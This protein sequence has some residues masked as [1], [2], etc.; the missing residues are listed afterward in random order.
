MG[1]DWKT[2]GAVAAGFDSYDDLPER[3][4]GYPTVF[5][6][7]KLGEPDVRTVL[8]YGCG[9]GKISLRVVRRHDVDVHAVD[10]S[11]SMLEIART[12]RPHPRITHHLIDRP[13]LD[14]LPD[15]SVDAAMC[16]Y[17]F[18]NIGDLDRIRAI[19][20][21]VHRVLR[22][23]GRFAV[24]DTNPDTTGIRFSTFESGAPGIRYQAGQQRRVQLHLPGGGVLELRDHH[25]PRDTYREVLADC[26]FRGITSVTPLLG[27]VDD[28]ED[29]VPGSLLDVDR[30]AEAVHAPFLI[31]TGEK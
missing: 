15:D 18:I 25:W 31:T 5:A 1:T 2:G 11:A 19:A 6:A 17:V 10:I 29:A 24:L 4:L 13:R 23:G 9:P 16:C 22:P 7:L 21:E 30:P 20:A 28:I 14:F 26:G 27:E 8:D 3:V 12:R